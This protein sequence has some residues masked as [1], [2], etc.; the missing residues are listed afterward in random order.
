MM[1]LTYCFLFLVFIFAGCRKGKTLPNVVYVHYEGPASASLY[2]T[3]AFAPFD[4]NSQTE[5]PRYPYYVYQKDSNDLANHFNERLAKF[6]KK[7]NIILTSEPA[8]YSLHVSSLRV[9]ESLQRQGFVDSCSFWYD[10][11][12]VYY[13]SI[14]ARVSITLKKNGAYIQDW[15]R[16]ESS[17][18]KVRDDK[19]DG[20]NRPDVRSCWDDPSDL[21]SQL[22]REIRVKVSRKLY[23][24][25]VK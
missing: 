6:L 8:E 21:V 24:L 17:S 15:T 7:N 4:P 19:R 10:T 18:E 11:D 14:N 23:E 1:R 2:P 13:S 16:E 22:A 3:G 12:Y 5:I 9:T 20:C 25:E